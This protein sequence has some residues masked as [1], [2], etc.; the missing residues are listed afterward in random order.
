MRLLLDE[1]IPKKLRLD[2]TNHSVISITQIGWGGKSNGILLNLMLENKFDGLITFDRNMQHQQ[3]FKNYPIIVF[4]INAEDNSYETLRFC[5]K[6]I[7]EK[8]L[9]NI[10]PGVVEIKI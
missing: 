4:V 2:F 8:L 9:K 7:E 6:I 5:V 1:N 3:N 10:L